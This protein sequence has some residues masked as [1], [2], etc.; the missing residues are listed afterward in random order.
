MRNLHV[1]GRHARGLRKARAL[2]REGLFSRQA[3]LSALEDLPHPELGLRALRI[4]L[5]RIQGQA[6]K[7]LGLCPD[8]EELD[9]LQNP[10]AQLSLLLQRARVLEALDKPDQGARLLERFF[11]HFRGNPLFL[12]NLGVLSRKA[13]LDWILCRARDA[14]RR[15]P[16]STLARVSPILRRRVQRLLGP[17]A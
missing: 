12:Y 14:L 4:E 1:Q 13:G 11:P 16:S 5:A 15:I 2:A 3:L 17:Q 6:S 8:L 7:A 10:K 9:R